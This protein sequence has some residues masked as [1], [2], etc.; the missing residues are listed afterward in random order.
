MIIVNCFDHHAC[1]KKILVYVNLCYS[2]Q[3]YVHL[4]K[5][6]FRKDLFS[7]LQI[8]IMYLIYFVILQFSL[9]SCPISPDFPPLIKLFPFLIRW[10]Y[11]WLQSCRTHRNTEDNVV[12]LIDSEPSRLFDTSISPFNLFHHHERLHQERNDQV[13]YIFSCVLKTQTERLIY[14][15]V[16]A[17]LYS[18]N[19]AITS[20]AW[21][22]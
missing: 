14:C 2:F 4:Q 22:E 13:S 21:D 20:E 7:S 16:I 3:Q 6:H 9:Y 10:N 11:F 17:I 5:L 15:M 1:R 8:V 18:Y 19:T 12:K